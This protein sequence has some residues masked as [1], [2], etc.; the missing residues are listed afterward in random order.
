MKDEALNTLDGFTI[1]KWRE[2]YMYCDAA[3]FDNARLAGERLEGLHRW[4]AQAEHICSELKID[5]PEYTGFDKVVIAAFGQ[6]RQRNLDLSKDVGK[7]SAHV[8]I[9]TDL[10]KK[11]EAQSREPD[12]GDCIYCNCELGGGNEDNCYPDC[13]MVKVREAIKSVR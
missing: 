4:S 11:L 9:L 2:K 8:V 1:E 7:L 12:E 5:W 10:L 13:I 6:L 3:R